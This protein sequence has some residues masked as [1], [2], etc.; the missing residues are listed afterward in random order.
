MYFRDQ[1]PPHFHAK[2]NEYEILITIQDL[3]ILRG[4]LPPEAFGMIMEWAS[5]HQNELL[6]NWYAIQNG[7]GWKKIEP[8]E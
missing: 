6:E 4:H 1:N 8:L 2:Y 3:R 5:S 7:R